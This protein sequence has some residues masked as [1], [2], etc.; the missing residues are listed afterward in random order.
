MIQQIV[1]Y[2]LVALAA[3]WLLRRYL[4]RRATGNCCGEPEC[5]AAKQT[6]KRIEEAARRR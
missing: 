2:A 3:L 6:A 4:K 1:A 5:P